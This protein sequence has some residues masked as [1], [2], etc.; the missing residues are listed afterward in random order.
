MAFSTVGT[1][2]YIAPEVFVQGGYNETVDWWSLGVILYEMLVGYPPFF[3]NEPSETCSK[4]L[5]W[6]KNFSIPPEAKL[7][8]SS[9]DLIRRLITDANERLGVNGVEEIK[10]H[11]FFYGIDWKRI[12]EKKA[13]YSPEVRFFFSVFYLFFLV[14]QVKS[15]IDTSNFDKFEEEEPWI[16]DDRNKKGKRGNRQVNYLNSFKNIIYFAFGK[17]SSKILNSLGIHLKKTS[18]VKDHI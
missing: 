2:D 16:V 9:I 11:P 12:R 4:I 7:S 10:A 15:E 18:K 14:F 5:Q 1:P 8:P 3:S 6:K 13:P 17:Y